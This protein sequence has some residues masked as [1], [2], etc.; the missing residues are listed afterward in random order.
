[1]LSLTVMFIF[2]LFVNG[3][4]SKE[5]NM[6]RLISDNTVLHLFI[7]SVDVFE[8]Q[9]KKVKYFLLSYV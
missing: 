8:S 7:T 9:L 1:M 2:L 6:I 3:S 5:Q 4:L